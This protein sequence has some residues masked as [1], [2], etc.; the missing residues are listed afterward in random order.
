[1]NSA[2]RGNVALT[3]DYI[4]R[5]VSESDGHRALQADLHAGQ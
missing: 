3:T 2:P 4:Y 1:M 5:G